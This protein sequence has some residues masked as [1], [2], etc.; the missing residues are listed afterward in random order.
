MTLGIA[1]GPTRR[2]ETRSYESA[3]VQALEAT[4]STGADTRATSTAV[5]ETAARW[6]STGLALANVTP[7]GRRT[8]CLDA[9]TL[10]YLGRSLAKGGEA[11]FRINVEGGVVCLDEASYWNVYGSSPRP[12][13]WAYQLTFEGPSS[14]DTAWLPASSVAHVRYQ[15]NSRFPWFGRSPAAGAAAS[16]RLVGG[17]EAQLSGEAASPSG[18]IMSAPDTGD[19]GAQ[20]DD[21]DGENDPLA[22][23]RKDMGSAAGRRPCAAD[24]RQARPWRSTTTAP[25]GSA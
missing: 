2:H 25:S 23:L 18:Y 9:A 19:R 15:W 11:V 5:V 6:W 22:S 16:S 14:V 13:T 4:A 7:G 24:S 21:D 20:G 10:A 8:W 3:I 1:S 12:S 17:I